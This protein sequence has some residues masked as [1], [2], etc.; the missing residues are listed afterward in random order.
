[1][2]LSSEDLRR[3]SDLGVTLEAVTFITEILERDVSVTRRD[4]KAMTTA[5]RARRYREKHKPVTQ[6]AVT[7]RDVSVTAEPPL[8]P[9]TPLEKTPSLPVFQEVLKKE[10]KE[11]ARANE[12]GFTEVWEVFPKRAGNNPRKPALASY[13]KALKNGA[14]VTEIR[15]GALRYAATCDAGSRFIQQCVTWLNQEGWKNDYSVTDNS[16]AN[17]TREGINGALRKIR[18]RTNLFDGDNGQDQGL[19]G[20]GRSDCY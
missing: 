16:R 20:D 12:Q 15:D 17:N 19:G 4:G 5:E 9:Q 3:L 18:E 6:K 1:M 10:S 8:V 7:S 14:T 11:I 2:S 13:L